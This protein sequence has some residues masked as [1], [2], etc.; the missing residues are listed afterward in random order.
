MIMPIMLCSIFLTSC[1]NSSVSKP[2]LPPPGMGYVLN[3]GSTV[4]WME[5]SYVS[6]SSTNITGIFVENVGPGFTSD[7]TIKSNVF[8]L[9]GNIS[10]YI[11]RNTFQS[12][13][14]SMFLS[15]DGYVDQPMKNNNI[16]LQSSPN[17]ELKPV[18]LSIYLKDLAQKHKIWQQEEIEWANTVCKAKNQK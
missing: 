15:I 7:C 14:G 18:K 2:Q 12:L 11:I 3:G 5:I 9:T 6:P 13:I 8:Y 4:D 10:H 17:Q 1:S 16:L